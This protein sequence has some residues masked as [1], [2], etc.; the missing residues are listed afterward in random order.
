MENN[1]DSIKRG[2]WTPWA[3]VLCY[4]CHGNENL[5][6]PKTDEEWARMVAPQP[7][8]DGNAVTFCDGC[9]ADVQVYDSVAYE[10]NL[11]AALRDRGF[12]AVMAQ[13]G[14]M[15]SGCS[16]TPSE[17]LR[18][19]GDPEGIG[20]ILITYNDSGDDQYW[21]GVYDNDASSAEVEWGNI[22]FRTQD[23]VL[24]WMFGNQEKVAK[25]EGFEPERQDIKG[26]AL[27][28]GVEL[29]NLDKHVSMA[30]SR[31]VGS[32]EGIDYLT[33]LLARDK[34]TLSPEQFEAI[35][36]LSSVANMN[37][38]ICNGGLDQYYFNTYD[39]G[40]EPF[41]DQD[42]AH[43]DK[44]AQVEMLRELLEFSK[45][46]Y[47]E[48]ADD[49]ERLAEIIQA[50][51]RSYYDVTSE[52]DFDEGCVFHDTEVRVRPDFD[53]RYYE[54]NEHLET[55]M[56]AYAQYL[57][58]SIEKELAMNGR[59]TFYFSFGTSDS[60]P[61][62]LGWV[63]VRAKDRM[64][65]CEMYSSHFP[66][67]DGLINCSFIYSES[68]WKKTSLDE[69]KPGQVCHQ[70]IA[71]WGPHAQEKTFDELVK[72]AKERAQKETEPPKSAKDRK[73]PEAE[74]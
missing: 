3:Q 27:Y 63:E 16:I 20:E 45:E 58:K 53:K 32:N 67:R 13:T 65:A 59:E 52:E 71:D 15:M 1:D 61:Y 2:V 10:H 36:A 22:S 50:F 39:Q 18:K 54:V 57:D 25:L 74:R 6:N 48:R 19:N 23:E 21:M 41:S 44:D 29:E 5:P 33:A 30:H 62:K 55:L 73:H 4:D 14:G 47:P 8:A 34:K 38:Q 37:Y 42:V 46:V 70:V 43:L 68:E 11:V 69:G 26:T 49:N 9:G 60:F 51:D 28:K 66:K 31:F 7:L 17:E 56:E 24:D 35:S 40:R 72:E 12:D 64:E